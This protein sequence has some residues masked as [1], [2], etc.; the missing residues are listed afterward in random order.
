MKINITKLMEI[1]KSGCG[2]SP[3]GE[4]SV[5]TTFYMGTHK[6]KEISLTVTRD[7]KFNEFDVDQKKEPVFIFDNDN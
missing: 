1:L 7:P 2:V 6:G 5:G 3:L 4:L